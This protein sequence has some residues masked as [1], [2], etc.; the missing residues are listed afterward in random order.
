MKGQCSDI[1]PN[2][3]TQLIGIGLEHRF[4]KFLQEF[5]RLLAGATGIVAKGEQLLRFLA[6]KP[7]QRIADDALHEVV[8]TAIELDLLLSLIHI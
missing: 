1:D 6:G 7:K 5:F 3:Y 4:H 8:F 2:I